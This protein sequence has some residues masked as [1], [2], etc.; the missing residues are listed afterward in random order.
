[1]YHLSCQVNISFISLD[2]IDRFLFMFNHFVYL[3]FCLFLVQKYPYK[4]AYVWIGLKHCGK[5]MIPF[6]TIWGFHAG[7]ICVLKIKP[8]IPNKNDKKTPKNLENLCIDSFQVIFW[9]TIVDPFKEYPSSWA[10]GAE[11]TCLGVRCSINSKVLVD[12]IGDSL[13]GE[14]LGCCLD[15][16]RWN[17]LNNGRVFG[18]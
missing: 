3:Y 17:M 6:H 4:P 14:F 9:P 10:P 8:K 7:I 18:T 5:S 1:M 13:F 15:W 16:P 11:L 12:A 2:S